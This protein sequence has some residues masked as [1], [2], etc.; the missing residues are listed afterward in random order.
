M[1]VVRSDRLAKGGVG[2]QLCSSPVK[3]Q[4]AKNAK[5]ARTKS[6]HL[7]IA[8][9]SSTTAVSSYPK[10]Q[11]RRQTSWSGSDRS[12][13]SSDFINP[14]NCRLGRPQSFHIVHFDK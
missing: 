9:S 6:D 5:N 13:Q 8:I 10:I 7:A 4:G 12:H 14:C 3:L 2:S 11:K 1:P